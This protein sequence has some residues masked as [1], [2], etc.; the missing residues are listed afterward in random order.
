MNNSKNIIKV[1]TTSAG[2]ELSISAPSTKQ[3]ITATNNKA[4]YFAEQAK[5]YS[6][7]AKNYRD[8]ALFY[9]EQNSD[10]TYEYI[11]NIKSSLEDT[12]SKKQD[13]GNYALKEEI[14][15]NISELNN[16]TGFITNSECNI[17]IKDTNKTF[18]S[19]CIVEI[20]QR[21]KYT[22]VNERKL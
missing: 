18:T 21:I 11:N 3:V 1:Y 4:Q 12:L 15:S 16:D 14:P 8:S 17:L 22:L 9:L 5:K 7:E 13:S 6:E 19:N 10:V 2:A 20:P